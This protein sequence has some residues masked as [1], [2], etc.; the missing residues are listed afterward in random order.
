[1]V[2]DRLVKLRAVAHL[3][4]FTR[5]QALA[6]GFNLGAIRWCL[7]RGLWTRIHSGVYRFGAGPLSWLQRARAALLLAGP[8]SALSHGSAA[9][10]LKFEGLCDRAPSGV[11]LVVPAGRRVTGAMSGV[12]VHHLRR[13]YVTHTVGR[14]PVTSVVRT[15]LDLAPRLDG[16]TYEF[17]LDSAYRRFP[18]LGS[19]LE[20]ALAGEHR[21]VSGMGLLRQLMA[22]R[23]GAP[24]DSRLETEVRRALRASGLPR[25]RAQYE[26]FDD[27]GRIMA[28][29]YAFLGYLVALHTD[30]YSWHHQYERFVRDASQRSRLAARGWTSIVVTWASFRDGTWLR[31]LARTLEAREPQLRLFKLG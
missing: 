14:T 6:A 31:D 13:R 28:I 29:D 16:P 30:G 5:E 18:L 4:V 10:L 2:D 20:R 9:Y 26:V 15:L 7:D 17:A 3:D 25:P 8:G 11:E 12:T 21:G 23:T 22:V 19:W 27:H 1:M 24:A